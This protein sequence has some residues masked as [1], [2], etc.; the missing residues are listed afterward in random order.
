MFLFIET[1][2]ANNQK[3]KPDRADHQCLTGIVFQRQHHDHAQEEYDH[4]P[5]GHQTARQL[6]GRFGMQFWTCFVV[7][8]IAPDNDDPDTD[9]QNRG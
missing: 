4:N 5:A 3:D 7:H 2:I 8:D 9:K 6:K 1:E